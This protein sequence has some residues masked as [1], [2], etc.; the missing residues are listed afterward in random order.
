MRPDALQ[1]LAQRSSIELIIRKRAKLPF[2]EWI[3]ELD[4]FVTEEGAIVD[5]RSTGRCGST[6]LSQLLG[7]TSFG[8]YPV[9]A[10]SISSCSAIKAIKWEQLS[11][12]R[13]LVRVVKS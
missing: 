10:G 7:T 8:F 1:P 3:S 13:Y 4:N 5:F 2:P 11:K 12:K 9:S 6:L